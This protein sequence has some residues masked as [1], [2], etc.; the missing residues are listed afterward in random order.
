ME[1]RDIIQKGLKISPEYLMIGTDNPSI[2]EQKIEDIL[3]EYRKLIGR[4]VGRN[5]L[6]ES[7]AEGYAMIVR[8]NRIQVEVSQDKK[9]P[10]NKELIQQV[11]KVQNLLFE[12]FE[13]TIS[14]GQ[15]GEFDMMRSRSS[16]NKEQQRE[17]GRK[18][19]KD[20]KQTV[21]EN[22][23]KL[24]EYDIIWKREYEN[25]IRLEVVECCRKVKIKYWDN[26]PEKEEII[27]KTLENSKQQRDLI[28]ENYERLWMDIEEVLFMNKLNQ[29]SELSM[30]EE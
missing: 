30:S 22:V 25:S 16:E 13:Y 2:S 8:Q 17:T 15:F 18:E 27:Q 5:R 20:V 14:A 1:K 4:P 12:E 21:D 29:I 19:R 6:V 26:S 28:E 24:I 7:L 3:T 23:K 11:S 9:L 10:E